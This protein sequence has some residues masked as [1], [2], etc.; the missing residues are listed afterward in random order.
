MT[1]NWTNFCSPPASEH[2]ASF[3]TAS[4]C[5]E[6]VYGRKK[7]ERFYRGHQ[8]RMEKGG[9]STE[10]TLRTTRTF[11]VWSG[12]LCLMIDAVR[13]ERKEGYFRKRIGLVNGGIW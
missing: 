13:R 1:N 4:V 11:F 6:L 2:F 12:L 7:N 10:M 5:R 8:R 9:S 3:G